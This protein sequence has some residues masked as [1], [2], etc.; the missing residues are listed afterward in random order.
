[1][2]SSARLE[3]AQAA[4][5]QG[6]LLSAQYGRERQAALEVAP[7]LELVAAPRG[8]NAE[9]VVRLVNAGPSSAPAASACSARTERRW[10]DRLRVG[11]V[12][13]PRR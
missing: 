11:E 9:D 4:I 6:R 1:V 10:A 12:A 3:R 7:R 13:R 5:E 8:A 2:R